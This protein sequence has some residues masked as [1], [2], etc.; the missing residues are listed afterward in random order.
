MNSWTKIWF[1]KLVETEQQR[2][3][4]GTCY[5]PSLEIKLVAKAYACLH[6]ENLIKKVKK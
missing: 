6:F 3:I 2:T 1:L 5:L 4:A